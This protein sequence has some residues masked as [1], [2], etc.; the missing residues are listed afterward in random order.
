MTD[1][2]CSKEDYKQVEVAV[3]PPITLAEGEALLAVNHFS[4]TANNISYA[5]TGDAL[6]YWQF[7]PCEKDGSGRI[8]VWGFATCVA[9][10]APRACPVG[11][12]IYGY[13]PM[14]TFL[15]VK[16]KGNGR[17]GFVDVKEH[18][19]GLPMA[20]NQYNFCKDWPLYVD[21]K[22]ELVSLLQ[23][24]FTTSWLL[25]DFLSASA[26]ED[27]SPAP[28]WGAT[29]VVLSSASSKTSIGLAYML[30]RRVGI[31]VIGLTSKGNVSFCRRLG[32]YDEILTCASREAR[33]GSEARS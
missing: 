15:C 9:S 24:L 28:F 8:P 31:K 21:G 2:C 23:P 26:G 25:D 32:W 4:F 12:R 18:R 16:P 14:S 1:I 6:G 29:S 27:S 20:Y 13:L 30:K 5:A 11:S 19:Q 33:K 10:R 17:G 7:F 3:A 22:E